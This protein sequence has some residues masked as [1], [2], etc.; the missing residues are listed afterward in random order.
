MAPNPVRIRPVPAFVAA[1]EQM[2][3][4]HLRDHCTVT[5]NK[6]QLS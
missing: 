3:V 1:R 2:S 6:G 4:E 5:V